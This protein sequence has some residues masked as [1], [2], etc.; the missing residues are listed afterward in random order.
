LKSLKNPYLGLVNQWLEGF[1][2]RLRGCHLFP[3]MLLGCHISFKEM[4]KGGNPRNMK[5][6]KNLFGQKIAKIFGE[7]ILL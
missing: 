6:M 3:S 2:R 7:K 5:K 4:V 1:G